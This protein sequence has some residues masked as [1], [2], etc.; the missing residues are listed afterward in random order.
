MLGSPVRGAS[1]R[2]ENGRN[3]NTIFCLWVG[4]VAR[5]TIWD[6][7]KQLDVRLYIKFRALLAVQLGRGVLHDE[8]VA[9]ERGKPAAIVKRSANDH[10]STRLYDTYR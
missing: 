9:I 5:N 1:T 7:Q 3:A 10:R 4:K 2:S 6:L 8:E